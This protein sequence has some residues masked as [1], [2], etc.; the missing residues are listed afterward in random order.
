MWRFLGFKHVNG[1]AKW[2]SF[3]KAI[4]IAEVHREYN[5]PLADIAEQ[6][7]DRHKTVQR[8]FRGLMVLDQ[9]EKMKVLISRIDI[10]RSLRFHTFT[11]LAGLRRH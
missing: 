1:P 8:L 4:Y 2:T 10:T 6:I 11:G 9:A 3:A 5:V 7:G